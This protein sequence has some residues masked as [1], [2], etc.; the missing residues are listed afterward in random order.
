[1]RLTG[2][3]WRAHHPHWAWAPDSGEGAAL[4]GGRFN[5][6][7]TPALYT[8]TGVLTAI[9]EAQ[10]GFA[11]K[12][13]PM[14]L[15]AYDVDCADI[16]DLTD[17]ATLAAQGITEAELRCAWLLLAQQKA[18]VPSWLLAT[19]LIAQGVAGILV[20]SFAPGAAPGERNA[21]FWR[22]SRDPPHKVMPIDDHGRLPVR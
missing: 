12:T 5:P 4:H 1:V 22:W 16:L 9:A 8:A 19:R 11:R 18:A 3:V 17:P 14:T 7:G 20:P 13:Q 21:V 10:Q 6:R 15:V 2:Q